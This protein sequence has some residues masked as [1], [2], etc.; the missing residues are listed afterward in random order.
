[1][2][3][4][5]IVQTSPRNAGR[6][7]TVTC[8]FGSDV[9]IGNTLVL[10]ALTHTRTATTL[11]TDSQSNVWVKDFDYKETADVGWGVA[12]YRAVVGSTGACT[13][14][15]TRDGSDEIDMI[16]M[17]LSSV[18]GSPL[19][20]TS[21]VT[22]GTWGISDVT[23]AST[24][25][26]TQADEL[27]IAAV[28]GRSSVAFSTIPAPTGYTSL[29][30]ANL[31]NGTFGNSPCHMAYKLVSATT[32]EAPVWAPTGGGSNSFGPA[33]LVV[34]TYK[35]GAP[36]P[37]ITGGT[38]SPVHGSTGNTL[39]GVN[40]GAS[41]TGSAASVIGGTGQ[42]ETGWNSTTVTY[43]A[44]RGVNLNGVAVN[45]VVTDPSGV[46][47][48]PYALTGFQPPAGWQYVTLT[49]VWPVASERIQSSADLAIGNQIEWDDATIDIDASGVIT[50]PPGTPDG[51]TFN[52]R[53]GV[54]GDG[55]GATEVQTYNPTS[56]AS[57]KLRLGIGMGL[58][59]GI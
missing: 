52:A 9:T 57:Q 1:M 49:S 8:T 40:F 18:T 13:V 56:A 33:A 41:Q 11:P 37:S 14:T 20:K 17:E 42:T 58:G 38:A 24:G 6:P 12:I 5:V 3:Q 21:S 28:I 54:S 7:G 2:T 59:I 26:L 10:V 35:G 29:G 50:W 36:S 47:S 32:A 53:V 48:D 43:T 45:A 15:L 4:P 16:A 19:D 25:T 31:G 30:T 51:Y 46:S 22:R 27:V 55:W 39:T 44:D 34:V 23:S